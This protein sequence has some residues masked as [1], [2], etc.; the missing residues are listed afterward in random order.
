[1]SPWLPHLTHTQVQL[2]RSCSPALGPCQDA[3]TP[4]ARWGDTLTGSCPRD[5]VLRK[6]LH[7]M[8]LTGE[9]F[10]D[11]EAFGQD[12]PGCRL[13]C[14]QVLATG[15]MPP[16]AAA[17]NQSSAQQNPHHRNHKPEEINKCTFHFI[18]EIPTINL[19]REEVSLSPASYSV[20]LRKQMT[21]H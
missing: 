5:G 15:Y 7:Q 1:M 12:R 21:P 3:R 4:A 17:T 18:A 10:G 9:D 13:S 20:S 11:F 8:L 6:V 16:Q 2:R 19:T 14:W